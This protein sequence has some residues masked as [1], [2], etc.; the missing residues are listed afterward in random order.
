[1]TRLTDDARTFLLDYCDTPAPSGFEGP[2][3]EV[4]CARARALGATDVSIDTVGNA[5]ATFNAGAGPRVL[6][7]SHLDEIGFVVTRITDEGVL[8]FQPIG[9]WDRAVV[10]GQRV[11]VVT[12]ERVL[13][14]IISRSSVHALT[15]AEREK[16]PKMTDLW[17]DVGATDKASCA[18]LVRIGDP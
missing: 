14:G 13:R 10:S 2:A 8:R 17:I 12:R 3:A 18:E 15:L 4:W 9:G 6:L 16:S 5:H 11:R 1:M 7:T